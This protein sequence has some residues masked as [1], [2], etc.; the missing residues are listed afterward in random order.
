MT[1][2]LTDKEKER[3]EK[4][5]AYR[6]TEE[7]NAKRRATRDLSKDRERWKKY[8]EANKE[9][10]LQKDKE[11]RERPEVKE[12]YKEL[13]HKEYL[14]K[15]KQRGLDDIKTLSDTYVKNVLT[16][17]TN[18]IYKDIPKEMVEAKRLEMLIRREYLKNT[19]EQE[20]RKTYKKRY[21]ARKCK[22]LTEESQNEKR[23]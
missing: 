6:R 20:R 21:L 1:E 12:R 17:R 7:Y 10:L 18:L 22:L 3:R 15:G 16:N 4:R 8:Y 13:K 11:Y 23:N 2:T 9:Y 5:N 19:P 14:R